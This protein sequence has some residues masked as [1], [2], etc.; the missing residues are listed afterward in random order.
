L[1]CGL[2]VLICAAR[3]EQIDREGIFTSQA[4]KRYNRSDT[5]IRE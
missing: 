1:L 4:G 3:C 5:G 2:G